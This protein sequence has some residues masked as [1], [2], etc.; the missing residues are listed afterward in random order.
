MY[1]GVDKFG[2]R[3][4]EWEELKKQAEEFDAKL[5][6]MEASPPRLIFISHKYHNYEL[7]FKKSCF[8]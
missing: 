4:Q 3:F 7:L 6:E 1:F 2:L 5:S 8:T